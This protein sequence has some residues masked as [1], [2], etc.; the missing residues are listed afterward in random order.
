MSDPNDHSQRL[1]QQALGVGIGI[2]LASALALAVRYGFRK[3]PPSILPESISPAV[4]VT[5]VLPTNHGQIVYH[6]SG[7]GEPLVFL[8]GIYPGAS[9]Y[10]WSRVYPEFTND[11]QVI[12]LDLLGFGESERPSHALNL[13]EQAES[14]VEFLKTV[15]ANRP[16]VV[17]ASGVSAKL[18]LLLA[19]QHPDFPKQL[20]TWLPLGVRKALRGSA[21][22]QAMGISRLP[23]L[24]SLAW[25]SYLS[26]PAFF[27]TWIAKIGFSEES[28]EDE[29]AIAVLTN[30]AG[31]YHAEV[32]IWGYL[33]G[34]F[35]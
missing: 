14:L 11:W 5:R 6:C 7:T 24:R 32:A 35:G 9:S 31:L 19:A 29:E 20:I 12:A 21:A 28:S 34:S 26:S 1:K 33:N 25:R 23:W 2:S 13:R 16:P 30:C 27:R 17:I 4:F 22:R 15:C 8:H 3:R 10:E 18:L